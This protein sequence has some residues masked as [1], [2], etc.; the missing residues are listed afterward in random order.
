MIS[1]KFFELPNGTILRRR[2]LRTELAEWVEV[3]AGGVIVRYGVLRVGGCG[4]GRRLNAS[5][6]TSH[7][8]SG[9]RYCPIQS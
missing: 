5:E 7:C 2:E 3:G 9:G 4:R 8:R 6:R 1:E